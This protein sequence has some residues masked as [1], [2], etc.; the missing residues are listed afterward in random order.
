MP[1][2]GDRVG[3]AR[4]PAQLP[5]RS[6]AAGPRERHLPGSPPWTPVRRG[7]GT[8][9]ASTSAAPSSP[10]GT[11][12]VNATAGHALEVPSGRLDPL[13]RSRGTTGTLPRHDGHQQHDH[14]G[15]TS[16]ARNMLGAAGA[17]AKALV[18]ATTADGSAGGSPDKPHPI[19]SATTSGRR[20]R[21]GL[22]PRHQHRVAARRRPHPVPTP[23]GSVLAARW[24]TFGSRGFQDHRRSTA[25]ATT[26]GPP[27]QAPEHDP[28]PHL[29]TRA[30]LW[31]VRWCVAT[32]AEHGT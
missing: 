20:D 26:A 23:P 22:A 8:L 24:D 27:R 7:A 1:G 15:A 6:P 30:V 18:L 17:V 29:S 13:R 16:V 2:R 4:W 3:Q 12:P 21:A 9:P 31:L 14:R 11:T 19:R 32:T 28:T 25:A 10:L 5:G